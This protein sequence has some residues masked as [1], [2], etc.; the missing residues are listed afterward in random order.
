MTSK[1]AALGPSAVLDFWFS[2]EVK[3][4]WFFGGAEF[5]SDV[6]ARFSDVHEMAVSGLLD[7]WSATLEGRLALI[8]LLDQ[9]SRNIYRN[10]PQGFANDPD[11]LRLA[12]SAL[13]RGDDLWL[14]ANRP[15]DWR[16]FVYMPFMH[17]EA[18]SDQRR[19]L[20]L[21]LTHGPEESVIHARAHH[22][23]IARFG[24]FPHRNAILGRESTYEEL[25]FLQQDGSRFDSV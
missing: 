4:K 20:D 13:R 3:P 14:K 2:D 18:L 12:N 24:R 25:A 6:S 15:A 19:C 23:I 9:M 7:S 1:S 21:L 16:C 17:S 8:L 11:A 5:D 10:Q 22:D